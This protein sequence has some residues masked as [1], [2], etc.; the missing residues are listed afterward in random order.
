VLRTRN[1]TKRE[2]YNSSLFHGRQSYHRSSLDA[3]DARKDS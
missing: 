1:E 2:E 3:E